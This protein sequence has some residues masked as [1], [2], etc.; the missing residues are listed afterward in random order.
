MINQ[1]IKQDDEKSRCQHQM[2][3]IQDDPKL[4][5]YSIFR[6]DKHSKNIR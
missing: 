3:A 2:K 6:V 1:M 5:V 4:K